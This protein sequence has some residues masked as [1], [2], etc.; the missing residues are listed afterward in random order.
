LFFSCDLQKLKKLNSLAEKNTMSSRFVCKK[1]GSGYGS[2]GTLTRH[3]E[4]GTC[5]RRL[6]KPKTDGTVDLVAMFNK[7]QSSV[8]QNNFHLQEIITRLEKIEF[9]FLQT[10]APA[11]ENSG[12]GSVGAEKINDVSVNNTSIENQYNYKFLILNPAITSLSKKLRQIPTIL[13]FSRLDNL[14]E[15]EFSGVE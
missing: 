14:P 15:K 7:L 11:I 9:A 3:V 8:D 5:D 10:H 12:T 4:D 1:C 13:D 2:K 6:A